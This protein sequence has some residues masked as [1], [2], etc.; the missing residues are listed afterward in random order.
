MDANIA[1][2]RFFGKLQHL[3]IT[4]ARFCALPPAELFKPPS[5]L[6]TLKIE[7]TCRIEAVCL[8]FFA[9]PLPYVEE[10]VL[11]GLGPVPVSKVCG[12]LGLADDSNARE[13]SKLRKFH[14]R[15]RDFDD[16]RSVQS[17]FQ[18]PRLTELIELQITHGKF[19]D[20]VAEVTANALTRLQRLH[21]KTGELTGVGVKKIVLANK[22]LR[23]LELNDCE[24]INPDADEWVRGRG[25]E[26]V[27]TF[28]SA[29]D[30][31]R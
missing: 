31:T 13:P 28:M 27:R 30:R 24:F 29:R 1:I 19:D 7:R 9:T 8:E 4:S 26:V 22:D 12:M 21:I 17:L 15:L 10:L 18:M 2:F 3:I 5:T 16:S 25:I 11:T 14:V 20:K 23:V 6:R